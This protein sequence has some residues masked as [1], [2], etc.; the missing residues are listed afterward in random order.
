[1]SGP[2]DP[3]FGV[4]WVRVV[5]NLRTA[6]MSLTEIADAASIAKASIVGYGSEDYR[7]EPGHAAGERLLLLWVQ[8]TRCRREDVPKWRRPLSTSEILKAHR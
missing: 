2:A 3:R 5:A 7:A 6:G 4:D 1:M 8:R